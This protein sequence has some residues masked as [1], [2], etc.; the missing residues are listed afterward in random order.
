MSSTQAI[1]SQ[2]ILLINV[3]HP[4]IGSR[5]PNEH[6]PPLG[7][8]CIGGPLLDAGHRVLLLDAELTPLSLAQIVEQ[9]RGGRPDMVL[10]GHSGSS[11]AHSIIIELSAMLKAAL[12]SLTII[13]GG[14]HPSY[15]WQET[16]EDHP[17]IDYIVRGEGEATAVAL[18]NALALGGDLSRINGIAYR[19][20]NGT[21]TATPAAAMI[22]DLDQYR[23]G[24]ELIDF[25]RYSYWGGHKAVVVQF[26]RGCPHQCSYCGQRGFWTR[27]RHRD[28]VKFA[29]EIARLHREHG[30]VVF[31]FA[32]ENFST[33]KQQWKTFLEALIAE[34]IKVR[35]VA[36]MRAGDVVRDA[37]ILHL[38]KQAG[39]ERFLLGMEHTD[40]A[41]LKQIKKGSCRQDDQQAIQLLRQHGILSLAT[42]VAGFAEESDRTMWRALRQLLTYDP[43]QIQMLYLTPHRWT[44]FGQAVAERKLIQPDLRRWDYKHQILDTPHLRPWRLFLWIKVIEII[45]QT[46]P[47]ALRRLLACPNRKI[48]E[49]MRWYY[50]IGRKVW[51]HEIAQFLWHDNRAKPEK[52]LLAY[53]GIRPVA[54]E[55]VLS[56]IKPVERA[57]PAR[58]QSK[59]GNMH[60]KTGT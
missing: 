25:N 60:L 47:R 23:I 55:M 40:E 28:P 45:M 51:F 13:Y 11:T 3:P 14:V 1:P 30:V 56:P 44:A 43:D 59:I 5:I 15:F 16:L 54:D 2:R 50:R 24:W 41:T 18:V 57:A 12:P 46:R 31:N 33:S 35:L 29:Q 58:R 37:D 17:A 49:A 10:F 21:V 42:W 6:L 26:S 19:N 38:Y 53:W 9:V 34:K 22:C 52:T 27:W 20:E 39:F 7:L 32:D 48:R 36:S 8:L 4:A